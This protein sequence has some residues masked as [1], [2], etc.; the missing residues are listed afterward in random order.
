MNIAWGGYDGL[1][2]KPVRKIGNKW[3]KHEINNQ[4]NGMLLVTSELNCVVSVYQG[5]REHRGFST[6]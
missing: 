2:V 5:S 6:S 4:D 1:T 3:V